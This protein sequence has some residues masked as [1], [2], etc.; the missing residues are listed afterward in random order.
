MLSEMAAKRQRKR[1]EKRRR[2][3]RSSP[4]RS[5]SFVTSPVPEYRLA[6][7]VGPLVY[8]RRQA[9]AALGISLATLDRR[10]VP[11]LKTVKTPTGTRLIPVSEI[12]RF[13][14]EHA[15]VASVEFS[16]RRRPGRRPAI[17]AQVVQRIHREHM[18]GKSLAD[19]ARDL[20]A[21][22]VPTSQGGLR[23][24]PSTVR[25]I[26]VRVLRD[27]QTTPC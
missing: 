11:A 6:E 10:I 23:W 24:W 26:L 16:P 15:E 22:G 27:S 21:S 17:P 9:A 8:T 20:T 1:I 25:S 5:R 12:E 3:T 14:K 18:E 19:I 2:R 13:L 7:P 4:G